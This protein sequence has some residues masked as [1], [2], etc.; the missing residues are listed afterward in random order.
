MSSS[1]THTLYFPIFI[2]R[3]LLH[4]GLV[5]FPAFEPVR[6]VTPIGATFLRQRAAHLRASSKRPRVKPSGVVPPPPSSTGDTTAKEPVDHAA[7]AA[8]VPP[9]PTSDD[10]DIQ[11][12]LETVMT[13]QVA[14]GQILV[15]ML[16]ELRALRADLEHLKQSPP[17]PPFDDV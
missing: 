17:P 14:H 6:I 8:D 10:L 9:P 11:H 1:T 12:M 7:T 3:I 13:V 5:E 16:D 4:L 2:H 15:D